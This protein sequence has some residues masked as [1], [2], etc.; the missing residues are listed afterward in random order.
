MKEIAN[1]IK[2][3]AGVTVFTHMR[4]DG[5]AIGSALSLYLALKQLN[6][7]CEVVDESDIPAKYFYFPIT[8]VIK[9]YPE[10]DYST[11]VAV[12]SSDE[13]RFGALADIFISGEKKKTTINIDHHISN[14]RFAKYNYVKCCSA[15]C[16]N[17]L[18]LFDEMG[19]ELTKEMAEVLML[20]LL[21]DSGNFSHSDVTERTFSTAARLVKA[22]VD[23]N[24]VNYNLVSK[25]SKARADLYAYT[26][27]NIRYKLNDRLAVI[28]IRLADFER[29]SANK[30]V[31]EGFVDFPLSVETVEV[32]VALMENKP[33]QYKVSLRSKGKA[34]V[35]AIAGVYGGGGHILASGCMLFGEIEEVIDKLTYTVSQYIDG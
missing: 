3:S 30:D 26:M 31:T 7:P 15:N 8:S 24:A 5:D 4:P 21:T 27:H 18:E 34:D 10:H 29:F 13:A 19:V 28:V 16:E 35:N 9:K 20:G 6:I 2:N 1:V 12:D 11:Y 25:Q 22:G 33:N 17:M 14:T 23:V 32:A